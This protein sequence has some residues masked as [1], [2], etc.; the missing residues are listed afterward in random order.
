MKRESKK[1]F[2][3]VLDELTQSEQV[4]V[5]LLF[6]LSDML[7][8]E[9]AQFLAA[10]P[11]VEDERR[12]E[13]MGHLVD[14]TEDNFSVEFSP[15]FEVGLSDPLAAVRIAALE[16]IWDATDVRLIRPVLQIMQT[17]ED[18]EARAAAARAL[19]HFVL[20]AEWGQIPQRPVEPV[21][22]ALL[23]AYEDE[24]TAVPVKRAALEALG[25]ANHPRVNALIEEAY[26][27]DDPGMQLSAIF[28]MGNTADPRWLPTI[29]EE[30][31]NPDPAVRAEAAQAAGAMGRSDAIPRLAEL[32]QDEDDEVR[33]AAIVGLGQI[34]GDQAQSLLG[35]LLEDEEYEELHE[36]IQEALESLLLLGGELDL[37]DYVEGSDDAYDDD[38]FAD[39]D[40]DDED[41][42]DGDIFD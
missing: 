32:S 36:L 22:T 1:P 18:V 28:A 12:R 40:F 37:F 33:A 13:I 38:D 16:G 9:E 2:S 4:P 26:E 6:R 3:E 7:P 20:L 17:D 14:L 39:E 29:L 35:Q 15:V 27:D 41:Y 42:D 10:W 23:A 30:L 5:H 34:G 21:I 24:E 19:A 25:A 31:T 11:E 8:E